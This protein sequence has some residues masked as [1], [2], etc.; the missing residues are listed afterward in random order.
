MCKCNK[1]TGKIPKI[2]MRCYLSIL[3]C[4]LAYVLKTRRDSVSISTW[5]LE[6][7][8]LK[9]CKSQLKIWVDSLSL[10]RVVVCI[11]LNE[12]QIFD[13]V[14]KKHTLGVI[15]P[16]RWSYGSACANK[17]TQLHFLP[18]WIKRNSIIARFLP[19]PVWWRRHTTLRTSSPKYIAFHFDYFISSDSAFWTWLAVVSSLKRVSTHSERK[20]H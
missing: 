18:N 5:N 4:S 11:L 10:A 2:C 8:K 13:T 20:T 14:Q 9:N 6:K 7:K 19:A 12:R 16:E 3:S 15:T 17:Q 1:V